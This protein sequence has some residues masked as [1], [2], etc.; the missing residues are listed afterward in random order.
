MEVTPLEWK[1]KMIGL[2]CDG[3]NSNL[4]SCSGLKGNIQKDVPWVIVSWCLAHRL[5]LSIKDALNASFF[6]S[7]DEMLLQIYYVYENSPKNV[8]S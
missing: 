2:G 4:G 5:E 3:T 1:S 6:K 8:L 7:I